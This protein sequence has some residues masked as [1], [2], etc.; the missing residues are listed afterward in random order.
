MTYI[1]CSTC[2]GKGEL[3]GLGQLMQKCYEC[4]GTRFKALFDPEAQI[5]AK[6]INDSDKPIKINESPNQ[7]VNV[8]HQL[9]GKLNAQSEITTR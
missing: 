8:L 9:R 2:N 1:K 3:I 7:K 4:N 5:E 6:P